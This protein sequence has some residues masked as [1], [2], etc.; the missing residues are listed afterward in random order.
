M[1]IKLKLIA[2][3]REKREEDITLNKADGIEDKEIEAAFD[4][5]DSEFKSEDIFGG[6]NWREEEQ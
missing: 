2:C 5:K 6:N 4:K 3:L 1:E